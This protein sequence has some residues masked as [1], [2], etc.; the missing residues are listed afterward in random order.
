MSVSIK[1]IDKGWKKFTRE[2]KVLDRSFV[3]VGVL[4]DAGGYAAG[5]KVNIASVAAFNE[6]GTSR[7]PSRPFMKQAFDENRTEIN[8]FKDRAFGAVIDKKSDTKTA[9]NMIGVFFKGKVQQQIAKG[10]FAPNKPSTV[11]Q[12]GSSKPLIDTGRLRQS[13]NFEVVLKG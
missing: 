3:K 2:M 12:K 5:A 10:S 13:I 9:L 1:D 7:I 8:S 4:S 6:F 11:A